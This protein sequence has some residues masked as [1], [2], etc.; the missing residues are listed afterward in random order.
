MA[1]QDIIYGRQPVKEMFNSNVQID[2]I[3]IDRKM[4]GEYEKQIRKLAKSKIIPLVKVPIQKLNT[5]I[6]AN[7]QGIL[8]FT[9]PVKYQDFDELVSDAL[10]FEQNPVVLILD[11]I[12][13][14][15]NIGAIARSAHWFGVSAIVYSIKNAAPLNADAIKTSAGSLLHIP[16]ARVSSIMHALLKLQEKGFHIAAT[17][18]RGDSLMGEIKHSHPLA[19][20]LGSEETGVSREVFR[21]ADSVMTIPGTGNTDSLNVSVS[22]GVLLYEIYKQRH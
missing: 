19:V 14:V 18:M 2:K 12:T 20:V 4:T 5:I 9:T 7:H 8:A 3:W 22:A 15:R 16:V 21:M 17:G 11:R 10:D 13:D 6:K 1:K